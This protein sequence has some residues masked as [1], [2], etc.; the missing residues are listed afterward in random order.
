L[1][2]NAGGLWRWAFREAGQE[3]T[4]AAYTRFWLS[5]LQWLLSGSQFLPGAD[6]ALSST[7]R[8]YTTEQPL[9]FLVATRNIDPAVYQPKLVISGGDHTVEVEPRA[10]GELWVAE[11]GPF[12]PG[13]YQVT[14]QNNVGKPGTLSQNVAVISASVEKRELSA[15]PDIMRRIA[16]TSGG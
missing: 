16:E 5:M 10:R 3:E 1:S 15:D 7:R 13:S 9:Q 4:E 11:A 8:Y 2:L 14:L 6:I 12:A